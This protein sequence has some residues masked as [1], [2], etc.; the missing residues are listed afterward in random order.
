M[1][2]N[3]LLLFL[4][5]H[6]RMFFFMPPVRAMAGPYPVHSYGKGI[7]FLNVSISSE[8]WLSHL[9]LCDTGQVSPLV[10]CL[11]FYK[12]EIYP[13]TVSF[14]EQNHN[15]FYNLRAV[16]PAILSTKPFQLQCPV[17]ICIWVHSKSPP[18]KVCS[19]RKDLKRRRFPH[20]RSTCMAPD[21][22]AT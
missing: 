21:Q 17:Y 6:P 4:A 7:I 5:G 12:V 9:W 3:I 18:H 14:C 20:C 11:K 19:W 13:Q 16:L 15:P 10:L 1:I 8:A 22:P 2:A